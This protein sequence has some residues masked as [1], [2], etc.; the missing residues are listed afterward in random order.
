[1]NNPSKN[2]EMLVRR[3][4]LLR[5]KARASSGRQRMLWIHKAVECGR[6]KVAL[7][8][9]LYEAR[10]RCCTIAAV[11]LE[12]AMC[13]VD[14]KSRKELTD[15]LVI[16]LIVSRAGAAKGRPDWKKLKKRLLSYSVK[17]KVSRLS[18]LSQFLRKWDEL[19][20]AVPPPPLE[21]V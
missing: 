3:L 6:A 7:Q 14:A 10:R 21:M 16:G 19:T 20:A 17:W 11:C 13:K 2:L 12:Q 8:N 18:P 9:E 5:K 1:M 15:M 4:T